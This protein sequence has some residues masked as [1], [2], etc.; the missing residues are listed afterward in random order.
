MEIECGVALCFV[1]LRQAGYISPDL[2]QFD[3][4]CGGVVAQPWRGDA[5]MA[6]VYCMVESQHVFGETVV[7]LNA[8]RDLH[9]PPTGALLALL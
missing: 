7:I 3:G 1:E 2:E 9:V 6:V 8:A 4:C 5:L